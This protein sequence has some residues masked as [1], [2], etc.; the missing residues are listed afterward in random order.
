MKLFDTIGEVVRQATGPM[1]MPGPRRALTPVERMLLVAS[2]AQ[3]FA[4]PGKNPTK[5]Q[6]DAAKLAVDRKLKGQATTSSGSW[7]SGSFWSKVK[8]LANGAGQAAVQSV[9]TLAKWGVKN[10]QVL[11]PLATGAVASPFLIKAIMTAASSK[12]ARDEASDRPTP[13]KSEENVAVSVPNKET[14]PP[15]EESPPAA[16]LGW[17][18]RGTP[19]EEEVA[20]AESG[21]SSERAALA[22][23][24]GGPAISNDGYRATVMRQAL[25]MAGGRAPTS[26]HVLL[27]ET[28]VKRTLRRNGVTVVMPGASPARRTL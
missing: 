4:G 19:S 8:N 6:L 9:P 24:Y 25:K 10:P 20:S 27:A 12:Q 22:R 26:K 18:G 14:A 2:A 16:S 28:K 23:M 5:Q 21:G 3:V 15:P 11:L 17:M 1:K 13:P 7:S